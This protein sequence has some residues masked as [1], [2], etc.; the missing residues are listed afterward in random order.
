MKKIHTLLT[1]FICFAFSLQSEAQTT[2]YDTLVIDGLSRN[3]IL[4]EP[5][6]YDGSVAVPLV[7]NLHGYGSNSSQQLFYGDFRPSADADN[8]IVVCP[9]GTLDGNGV[10]YWNAFVN[11]GATDDVSFVSQLIDSI[12][13]I[14][15]IDQ[16]QVFATGMSNGGFMSYKLACELTNKIAKIA[17]VTGTMNPGLSATCSPSSSIPVM[18]IHGTSDQ[19]VPYNGIP[20]V[21]EPIAD[22]VAYWVNHNNCDLTPTITAV[23]DNDPNDNSTAER[24]VYANGDDNSEVIH[25]KITGGGHT[26]PDA[27][28]DIPGSNTNHDFNASAAIWEFFKGEPFVGIK[29]RLEEQD[30][31]IQIQNEILTASAGEN[32]KIESLRIVN[33]LGQEVL[34]VAEAQVSIHNLNKGLYYVLVETPKGF[35]SKAFMK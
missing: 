26:W 8:F 15:N 20:N 9:N 7:I 2:I 14:Y 31:S 23:P 27:I 34:T 12:S 29:D 1:L 35:V 25:Y 24:I 13:L 6:I 10:R 33:T 4:Y 5:A 21:M 17:S 32:E 11:G 19:T 30:L 22:V 3:Y 28:I 18:E 16:S